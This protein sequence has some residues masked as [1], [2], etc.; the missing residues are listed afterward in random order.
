[1]TRTHVVL[2]VAA[3]ALGARPAA[4]QRVAG[5][6]LQPSGRVDLLASRIRAVQAGL[7]LDTRAGRYVRLGVVGAAG[8]SWYAGASGL[9]ARAEM[10]GRFELDPDFRSRW[11]P[12]F[13]AGLG[14]RYD[15]VGS[16]R[17]V[18]SAAIGLEGPNAN[19]VIP[20]LEV[21][22]GGGFR[23]GIGLRKALPSGR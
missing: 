9:S 4:A 6:H 8:E 13:T 12:Y 2:V 19:G 16:W 7:E 14:A 22:W 23:V 17:G 11:A 18:M 21:G 10:V 1:M 20:F 3:L 15:R 5:L